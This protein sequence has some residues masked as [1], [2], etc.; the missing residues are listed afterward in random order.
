M[1]E[2]P[3]AAMCDLDLKKED[4][5]S[6]DSISIEAT[7]GR[8]SLNSVHEH[9]AVVAVPVNTTWSSRESIPT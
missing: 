6:N 1:T 7:W 3:R 9:V 8:S 5:Q 4:P 2:K